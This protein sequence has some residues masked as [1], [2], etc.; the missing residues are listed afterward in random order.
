MK[1]SSWWNGWILTRT[2]TKRWAKELTNSTNNTKYYTSTIIR[3][4]Q[5]K[6]KTK[7][8]PNSEIFL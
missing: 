5:E 3:T 7:K 4:E 8:S 2:W 6:E 1:K